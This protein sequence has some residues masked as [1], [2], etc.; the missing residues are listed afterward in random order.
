MSCLL[1]IVSIWVS[2]DKLVSSYTK[3]TNSYSFVGIYTI[4][5]SV[6]I[7][8]YTLIKGACRCSPEDCLVEEAPSYRAPLHFCISSLAYNP[9]CHWTYADRR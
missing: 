4:G 9:S 6:E 1:L 5:E 2:I 8:V 3:D 7:R